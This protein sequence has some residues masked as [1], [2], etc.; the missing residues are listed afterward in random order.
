MKIISPSNLLKKGRIASVAALVL[1]QLSVAGIAHAAEPT[2][3]EQLRELQNTQID[4]QLVRLNKLRALDSSLASGFVSRSQIAK[5]VVQLPLPDSSVDPTTYPLGLPDAASL[6]EGLTSDQATLFITAVG[7]K[8]GPVAAKKYRLRDLKFPLYIELA[9]RDLIFP[10]TPD[11]WEKSP[12]S[13]GGISLTCV[14]DADGK[15]STSEAADR[16]GFAIS[17]VVEKEGV[18]RRAD[19]SVN[20]NFKSDGAAYSAEDVDFLSRIDVELDRLG[21]STF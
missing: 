3:K 4:T 12:L 21:F 9:E 15:L 16:F 8:S 18:V 10:Y 17:D 19:T 14:L 13:Q 1:A 7:K 11:A 2:M 6:D 20:I 5:G